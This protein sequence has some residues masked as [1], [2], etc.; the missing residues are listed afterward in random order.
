M[1][2]TARTIEIL[3]DFTC[4]GGNGWPY[5]T[6][7]ALIALFNRYGFKETYPY[8]ASSRTAFAC[9]KITELA[10][11]ERMERFIC[12]LVSPAN[13]IEL[14]QPV[15]HT[16]KECLDRLNNLLA[17]DSYEVVP[18]G[19]QGIFHKVVFTSG[20]LITV[21]SMPT[22]FPELT[23]TFIEEQIVKCRQKIDSED[24]DGAITNARSLIE[25]VLIAIEAELS[26]QAPAN[27]DGELPKLF[28]RVRTLLNMDASRKDISDSLKQVL[29]GLSSI[30]MGLAAMRNKMSDSHGK[31]Y[32]PER[33]HAKLAVNSAKTLADF[34][35]ETTDYQ[36]KK[37]I[38]KTKDADTNS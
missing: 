35:F 22:T 33:H 4:G 18:M 15:L 11:H 24:Y 36:Q 5:R 9:E 12:D 6:G 23:A 10:P 38:L 21:E 20:S 29:N 14:E 34:L 30:V 27:F 19:R 26:D 3:A 7:S 25:H 2:L 16:P 31:T 28:N 32:R 8:S 17:F 13:W 37:G 1:K